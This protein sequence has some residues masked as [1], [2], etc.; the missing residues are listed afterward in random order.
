MPTFPTPNTVD[1]IAA[2]PDPVLRN[3]KITHCYAVLSAKF[4]ERIAGEANWCT[5]ATW[6]SKQAGQTIRKEDF[7]QTIEA[8]LNAPDTNGAANQVV[9]V[10][11]QLG[12]SQ[13][14][15]RLRAT[16]W[17]AL[18]PSAALERASDA[19]ARGNQKVFAEIGREFARFAEVCQNDDAFHA[20]HIEN[21]CAALRPGEPPDGQRYL[22]QAFTRYY[23]ALFEADAKTRC[24]L[25]LLAN[26][27]IGLH[28]QT[29]LQPEIAE[30][31]NAALLDPAEFTRR[32]IRLL[33]P[34]GGWP[35]EVGALLRRLLRRPLLWELAVSRLIKIARLH[36]RRLLTEHMM[37]LCFPHGL[38][39]RLSEDIR[40]A[41]PETLQ[42]LLNP[43]LRLLLAQIDP[44]PDSP[45]Q[46]GAQ[47]WA[48]LPDR[49]HFI[50]DLFRA[51]QQN[52]ILHELPFTPS[53]VE[54][55]LSGQLP[56]GPV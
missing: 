44:T 23:Q 32:F 7:A 5:F 42:H 49:L 39:L 56:S 45:Y 18:N 34:H 3:L 55:I 25:M 48:D 13:D 6:A 15:V 29:R 21:F 47:D 52:A 41:F 12:L 54:A 14:P 35:V 1:E 50:A 33:F 16:V 43:E 19:V 53:Q 4:N 10:A 31:L 26:L 17:D 8:M 36:L 37:V 24:E 22:R 2:W 28:E 46:S 11:Q 40:A 20:E 9:A 51:Y 30:A 38:R 27:E